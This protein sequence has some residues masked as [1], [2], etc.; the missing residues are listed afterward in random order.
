MTDQTS[1]LILTFIK[2]HD[3][4]L[5]PSIFIG[6]QEDDNF[7]NIV[8]FKNCFR[9]V[10]NLSAHEPNTITSQI[11]AGDNYYNSKITFIPESGEMEKR[12]VVDIIQFTVWMFDAYLL[13]NNIAYIS[14]WLHFMQFKYP[15]LIEA[16][17]KQKDEQFIFDSNAYPGGLMGMF[18]E[19]QRYSSKYLN[20]YKTVS[21]ED[22]YTLSMYTTNTRVFWRIAFPHLMEVINLFADDHINVRDK[23]NIMGL[24]ELYREREGVYE[25]DRS[26]E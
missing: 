15:H 11:N 16:R 18:L 5:L 25:D 13:T 22:P 21:P 10:R 9:L 19:Y 17:K 26:N 4:K 3:C 24:I 8:R 23:R 2:T 20:R 1:S 6:I 12:V 7:S 14:F